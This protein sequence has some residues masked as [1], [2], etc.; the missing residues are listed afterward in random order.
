MR[1]TRD[2]NVDKNGEPFAAYAKTYVD[3]KVFEIYGK[4]ASDVNL[5][6]TEQMLA[7]MV[8]KISDSGLSIEFADSKQN[9]KAHGHIHGIKR[10]TEGGGLRKVRRDFF[11]VPQEDQIR[12]LK[13]VIKDFQN[14]TFDFQASADALSTLE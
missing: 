13:G 14:E 4:S 12:I 10:R 9:D 1:R 5:T 7:S 3:S 6:L 2:D 11:G 8:S